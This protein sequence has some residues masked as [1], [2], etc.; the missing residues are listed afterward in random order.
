MLYRKYGKAFN[1]NNT[2]FT[3]FILHN[4]S[5]M[6]VMN[7]VSVSMVTLHFQ[8]VTGYVSFMVLT[9]LSPIFQLYRGGQFYWWRK[10]QYTEKTI[11]LSQITDKLYHIMLHRVHLTLWVFFCLFCHCIVCPSFDLRL[12]ISHLLSSSFSCLCCF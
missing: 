6:F 9:P 12:L 11:D 5:C 8:N 3:L 1:F 2:V 7:L 4:R 10:P